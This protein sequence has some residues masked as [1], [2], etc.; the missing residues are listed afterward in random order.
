MRPERSRR[1]AEFPDQVDH[2]RA[3]GRIH[4]V[5]RFVHQ[6]HIGLCTSAAATLI[7]CRIPFE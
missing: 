5:Q 3:L 4:S 2:V 6:Q 1:S 7:R